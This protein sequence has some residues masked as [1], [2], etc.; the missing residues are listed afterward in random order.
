MKNVMRMT[1]RS[2]TAICLENLRHSQEQIN[3]L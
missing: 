3:L 1:S 2:P